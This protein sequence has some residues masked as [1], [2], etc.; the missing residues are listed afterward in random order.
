MRRIVAALADGEVAAFA[1]ED[2]A[3]RGRAEKPGHEPEQARFAGAI[4]TCEQK[5]LPSTKRKADPGK[6]RSPAPLAGQSVSDEPC[7][8]RRHRRWMRCC[9]VS[10]TAPFSSCHGRTCSGGPS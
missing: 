9:K 7:H 10:E 8:E 6:S 2:E 3:P 1:F 5:K 4:R